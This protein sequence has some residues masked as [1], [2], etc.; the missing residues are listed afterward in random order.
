M[1][2]NHALKAVG[3]NIK[4]KTQ[5]KVSPHLLRHPYNKLA[6]NFRARIS[7]YTVDEQNNSV[8]SLVPL[9]TCQFAKLIK[10]PAPTTALRN[11]GNT[12]D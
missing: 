3:M 11:Y 10:L 7:A 1:L 12:V 8:L 2:I 5:I 6:P 9:K 4:S